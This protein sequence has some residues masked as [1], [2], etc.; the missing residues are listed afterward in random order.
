ARLATRVHPM[1]NIAAD[2]GSRLI[3]TLEGLDAQ[4]WTRAWGGAAD[5]VRDAATRAEREGRNQDAAALYS[6]ASGLYFMGRFPCPNHPAKQRCA[7]L[8]RATYLAAARLWDIPAERVS[9]PFK[10]RANEG[11]EI[12]FLVRRPPRIAKPPVVVM[13]G[14]VD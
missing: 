3:E 12:V 10:G 2:E 8:E 9:V 4:S 14:G 6:R 7:E 13:W 5:Q 1:N 11:G